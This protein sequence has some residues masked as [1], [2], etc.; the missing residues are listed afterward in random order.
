MKKYLN[1]REV[2]QMLDLEEYTIRYWDS[3]NPKTNKLRFEGLSTKSKKGT[4]YFN[5]ENINRLKQ[6]KELL[7]DNGKQNYTLNLANKLMIINKKKPGLDKNSIK[8]ES[9]I[10]SDKYEK[11][12]QILNKMR[13]LLKES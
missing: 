1:I 11:I 8:N 4:R 9:L 10:Q 12:D 5:I 6:L 7:Y 2:S 3:H 13:F